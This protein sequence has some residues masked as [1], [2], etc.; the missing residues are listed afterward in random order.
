MLAAAGVT[1]ILNY[2]PSFVTV[3]EGVTIH[4]TDPVREMLHTLYYL[5]DTDGM[6]GA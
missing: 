2:S 1:V 6:A 5:S 4:N 3:P